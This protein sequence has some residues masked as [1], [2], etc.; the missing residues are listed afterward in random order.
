MLADMVRFFNQGG[1]FMWPILATL[2]CAVTIVVERFLFFGRLGREDADALVPGVARALNAGRPEQARALVSGRSPLQRILGTALQRHLDGLGAEAVQQGVEEAAV[3]EIPRLNRRVGHL[4]L[5]ANVATLTGLL[6]TIFG[7]QQSFASLA[8]TEAAQKAA[9]LAA[10][11]SVALN[12]TAFGLMV[13]I[14]CMIAHALLTSWQTRRIEDVDAAALSLLHY[15]QV[16][17]DAGE[18]Q[19]G[20]TSARTAGGV[21]TWAPGDRRAQALQTQNS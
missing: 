10:G 11:I 18:N 4:A 15:L 7:L 12:T 9:A 13:A 6:G 1:I 16:R 5:L 14:P 8:L 20:N 19:R 3:R 17:R 2:A 21:E